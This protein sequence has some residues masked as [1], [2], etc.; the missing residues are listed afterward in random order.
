[1]K[2][3]PLAQVVTDHFGAIDLLN[4]YYQ[5]KEFEYRITGAKTYPTKEALFS[6]LQA[7]IPIVE[8][9]AFKALPDR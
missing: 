2:R 7:A 1:M 5:A 6:F 9:D 8:P 3:D 4:G